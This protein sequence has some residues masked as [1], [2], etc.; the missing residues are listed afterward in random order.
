MR[1]VLLGFALVFAA[2]AVKPQTM[3]A[4]KKDASKRNEAAFTAAVAA[5][6]LEWVPVP[7]QRLEWERGDDP[8]YLTEDERRRFVLIGRG[9][10]FFA[11]DSRGT[12][13]LI[14]EAPQYTTQ[15]FLVRGCEPHPMPDGAYRPDYLEGVIL[16]T[17]EIYGGEKTITY[18]A[19]QVEAEYRRGRCPPDYE[20][21]PP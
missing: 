14:D 6:G 12:L 15:R 20:H 9:E 1:R 4:A 18:P 13:Y 8:D 19:V 17:H 11:R 5:A 10:P 16:P 2:C 7:G 21:A 3:K